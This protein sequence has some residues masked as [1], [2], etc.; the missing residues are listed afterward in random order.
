MTIIDQVISAAEGQ[1]YEVL[2]NHGIEVPRPNKHGPC[3]VC[4]GTDR[5]HFMDKG[6]T[7]NWHCR[8]CT[9]HAGD[10]LALIAKVANIKMIEA[11]KQ[12]APV[13]GVDTLQKVDKKAIEANKKKAAANRKKREEAEK[14]EREKGAKIAVDIWKTCKPA[15]LDHPY[16][17]KKI[18]HDHGA[19]VLTAEHT[20]NETKFDA[21]TLVIPCANFDDKGTLRIQSLEFISLNK[22]Q[23]L[24]GGKR[25][26][27]FYVMGGS[28]TLKDAPRIFVSEGF[29]TAATIK[30]QT[31]APSVCC[32]S[33]GQL[34]AVTAALK[35]HY[36][37]SQIVVCADRD[38]SGDGEEKAKKTGCKYLLVP[39]VEG[40]TDWNDY[41]VQGFDVVGAMMTIEM[42]QAQEHEAD[43]HEAH[44]EEAS[45]QQEIEKTPAESKKE[46]D[47]A[48]IEYDWRSDLIFKKDGLTIENSINNAQI[49]FSYHDEMRGVLGFNEFSKSVDVLCSPPWKDN[50]KKYPRAINDV[51]DTRA[52]A[53]LERLGC[54]LQIGNVHNALVSAAHHNPFNP[55]V[56]FLEGLEWDGKARINNV[57]HKLFGCPDDEYTASVSRRFL[58][59]S[60]AR[61][62]DAGCKMDTMLIL[63]GPQGLKKSTAVA[64]L[65]GEDWFTDELGD[66]GSKDAAL[67]V[68][69][70]WAV[71]IAELATMNRAESNRIKEWITRREDRF[72][73]PY[74]RNI[75][76]APRQCVLIG[77][78]NPEGGYLKDATGGRRFWPVK[79]TLIN[80]EWIKKYRLQIW[81]EAV[82][83]YKNNERWWFDKDEM[84][85]A[86][87]QQEM[88]YESD[89]WTDQIKEFLDDPSRTKQ[90][91]VSEIMNDCLDLPAAQQTQIAANRVAKVLTADGYHRV[92]RRIAG[93]L[94]W[95]YEMP[96]DHI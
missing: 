12:I 23:G 57:L 41:Y 19:R 27:C 36:P 49:L 54:K 55:L 76:R 3:P 22:K 72:R 5:F 82:A 46:I 89:A 48:A 84:H 39:A 60:V 28:E 14:A 52:T 87:E 35:K 95:V 18:I 67:Q 71:E 53:W 62:I 43:E 93:K 38:E 91:S 32:F 90:I 66:L 8:K 69:G 16:L 58:V 6:G 29:A 42:E 21:G 45:E 9:P 68:Q 79:C 86:Q 70:V 10:G 50:A 73:P 34:K 30:E 78:V 74:G 7:G 11:A 33:S 61:A 37:D 59:G 24:Y 2:N 44:Y 92:R 81:A 31:G 77:T 25:S 40:V 26:G 65:Y 83:A 80:V 75:V 4:G 94:K 85:I 96:E 17:Q 20:N 13:L 88:R 1:W 64:E 56:D 47:T 51:D 63:E 15:S